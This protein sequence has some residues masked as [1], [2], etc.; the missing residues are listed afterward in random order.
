MKDLP[1]REKVKKVLFKMFDDH[2][3]Y[4]E[5]TSPGELRKPGTFLWTT[6]WKLAEELRKEGIEVK[7]DEIEKILFEM[8]GKDIL[9]RKTTFGRIKA[10]YPLYEEDSFHWDY[11]VRGN[12]TRIFI[13]D[14]RD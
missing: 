3:E 6:D 5:E 8:D 9:A 7:E 12:S 13:R 4:L 14:N 1:Y 11:L 2:R 10:S